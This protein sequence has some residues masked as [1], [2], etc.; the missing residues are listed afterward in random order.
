MFNWAARLLTRLRL[1]RCPLWS[2][3]P[4][5]L[6]DST[7]Y[8]P[9]NSSVCSKSFHSKSNYLVEDFSNLFL[10]NG[11]KD[12]RI[13]LLKLLFPGR[14]YVLGSIDVYSVIEIIPVS[15]YQQ[16]FPI[17]RYWFSI[18]DYGNNNQTISFFFDNGTTLNS[19]FEQY[20]KH[21]QAKRKDLTLTSETVEQLA[22][23]T[24]YH[25]IML[26]RILFLCLG[27]LRIKVVGGINAFATL[28][29]VLLSFSLMPIVS[30]PSFCDNH[31]A[32]I[33]NFIALV[34]FIV[35]EHDWR[36]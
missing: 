27:G 24:D 28:R 8:F 9:R 35:R 13:L 19:I 32:K 34:V 36:I 14:E 16:T 12:L 23:H 18:W 20:T 26:R 5:L 7:E 33:S 11:L 17:V 30:F 22:K 6:L 25:W 10:C 1:A 3:W 31:S 15:C 29:Q 2:A 21:C 4:A